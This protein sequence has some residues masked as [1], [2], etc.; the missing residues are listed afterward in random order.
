M[1]E[2]AT[3]NICNKC[4]AR[5]G[6]THDCKAQISRIG[7]PL[8]IHQRAC[9]RLASVHHLLLLSESLC[10]R[11]SLW[12]NGACCKLCAALRVTR[13]QGGA[14]SLKETILPQTVSDYFLNRMP[15]ADF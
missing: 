15:L 5:I 7:Q 12:H 3:L 9:P 8:Y 13:A 4:R 14:L 6:S 2:C 1:I 10:A 11:G